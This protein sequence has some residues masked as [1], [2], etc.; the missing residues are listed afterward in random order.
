MPT[1]IANTTIFLH[2][3]PQLR[4]FL[5]IS[6]PSSS[7]LEPPELTKEEEVRMPDE[8]VQN[9]WSHKLKPLI[10]TFR[11]V[12]GTCWEPGSNVSPDEM[13]IK[14]Y[15][16]S[17][18]TCRMPKNPIKE[19]YNICALCERGYLFDFI[20][21]SRKHG[22][23][24]LQKHP[25]L[26][27][28]GSMVLQIGKWLP[29]ATV[30]TLNENADSVMRLRKRPTGSGSHN[31][32]K[33]IWRSIPRAHEPGSNFLIERLCR[34]P[35]T[36]H[37]FIV[38][39]RDHQDSLLHHETRFAFANESTRPVP[40]K[41]RRGTVHRALRSTT[42]P[43]PGDHIIEDF[44]DLFLWL[45]PSL[46]PLSVP[47]SLFSYDDAI[48]NHD[49]E[50]HQENHHSGQT[51]WVGPLDFIRKISSNKLAEPGSLS[52]LIWPQDLSR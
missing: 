44:S 31:R 50:H 23:G 10:S 36:I 49:V 25:K 39:R 24:E 51:H 35:F 13:M 22:T 15:G 4:R 2:R 45:K 9:R 48:N 12:C 18:H 8:E 33:A 14:S 34:I 43:L 37:L 27:P 46:N 42:E 52:T 16:R 47:S 11:R 7:L 3:F 30:D 6:K 17:S 26:S 5:H 19:G 1:E 28:T 41:R 29:K 40:R 20:F 21:T 38:V 32:R